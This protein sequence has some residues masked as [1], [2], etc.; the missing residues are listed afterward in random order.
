[1]E[2]PGGG[3]WA[4]GS[5]GFFAAPHPCLYLAFDLDQAAPLAL[6][7]WGL[8]QGLREEMGVRVQHPHCSDEVLG[9]YPFPAPG[10]IS[11]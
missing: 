7:P 10:N 8:I 11:L 4:V 9:H 3:T 5:R 2:W 1:M 6:E